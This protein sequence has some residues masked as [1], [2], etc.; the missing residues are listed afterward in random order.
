MLQSAVGP[1]HFCH[2]LSWPREPGRTP[3]VAVSRQVL[4]V[5]DVGSRGGTIGRRFVPPVQCR[6]RSVGCWSGA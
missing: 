4:G 3:R 1:L 6:S 5:R 2:R